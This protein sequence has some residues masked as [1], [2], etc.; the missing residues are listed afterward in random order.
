M[1]L[2][3][4]VWSVIGGANAR[5]KSACIMDVKA[6]FGNSSVKLCVANTRLSLHFRPSFIIFETIP[7]LLQFNNLASSHITVTG[8]RF[9]SSLYLKNNDQRKISTI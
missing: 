1:D 7:V 4:I 9:L 2:L 6:V 8:G 5:C 3:I